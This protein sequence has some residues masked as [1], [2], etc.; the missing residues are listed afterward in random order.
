MKITVKD[1]EDYARY[2]FDVITILKQKP[3]NFKE[4]KERR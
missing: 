1:V 4:W 2:F 3:L